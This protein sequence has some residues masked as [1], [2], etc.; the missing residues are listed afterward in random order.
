[1]FV[2][3]GTYDAGRRIFISRCVF[4]NVGPTTTRNLDYVTLGHVGKC[5]LRVRRTV[6]SD[7]IS[8]AIIRREY[9]NTR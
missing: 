8:V 4:A 2:V 9:A 7:H 5:D 1:M 3:G 6:D